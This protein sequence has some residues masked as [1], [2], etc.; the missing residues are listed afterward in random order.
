MEF[1]DIARE[2]AINILM[3]L[4]ALMSFAAAV[5]LVRFPDLLSRM[6]AATKPQVLGLLCFLLAMAL[7]SQAWISVPLLALIWIF[8]LMT[9]PVSAHMLGRAG[10]RTKHVHTEELA[11]DDLDVVVSDEVQRQRANPPQ[12]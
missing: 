5:G 1:W 12:A 10:Y 3:I 8:Q 4:G 6:H 11:V 7:Q 2:W 9:V